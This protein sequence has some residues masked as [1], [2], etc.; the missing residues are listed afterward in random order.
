MIKFGNSYVD[1]DAAAHVQ[2]TG[3][4]N[5]MFLWK[6]GG[7]SNVEGTDQDMAALRELLDALDMWQHG[8]LERIKTE[9]PYYADM[10]RVNAKIAADKYY[11]NW[12]LRHRDT[13]SESAET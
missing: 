5:V 8:A 12:K 3:G 1:I 7:L 2:F 11:E 6:S 13:A 4:N 9:G 10:D